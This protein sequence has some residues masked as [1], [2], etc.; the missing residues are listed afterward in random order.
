[1][2]IG[3]LLISVSEDSV[4]AAP[5]PREQVS[6]EEMAQA[7]E[8]LGQL[9]GLPEVGPEELKNKV[10]EIGG[11]R[12]LRSVPID[13]MSRDELA[14]YIRDLFEDEYPPAVAER[15]ERALR[16]LGLLESGQDLRQIRFRVL[17]ENIAGFYDERPG[18]KQLFAISSG[19]SLNLMNQ[20]ILAHELRH[21]IQDQHLQLREL[22]GKMSDY[23]DRRLAALSL[24]EGDATL[25][26][27]TYMSSGEG[28]GGAGLESLLGDLGAQAMD[29]R[30]LAEMFAGPALRDAPPV[31][32]EQL[33][34]PY[35]DGM[36]LASLIYEKGGF[37]LL[38]RKL[39]DLPRST[40]QVL[41]P[42]KYLERLDEPV[43]VHLDVGALGGVAI[44]S[45][46]RVGE[47]F[48]RTLFESVLSPGQGAEAA[49]GW[50]GDS[51]AVWVDRKGRYHLTWKTIWDTRNDAQ[52]FLNAAVQLYSAGRDSTA[53]AGGMG[54][55]SFEGSDGVRT[56]IEHN[57]REVT[58][59]REGFQ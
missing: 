18:V 2:S 1:M 45:E 4:R 6:E 25:V 50:G 8:L 59:K 33:I 41:H 5:S 43:E 3:I 42:E 11:L 24:I 23:D 30:S 35:F 34:T 39:R 31:V 37:D 12:F 28:A 16:A 49:A 38:N 32:R 51:Y 26:M 14:S 40:E 58:I 19:R 54:V 20:L 21:A 10:E 55:H 22:L 15:E 57:G 17:N 9:L 46:G 56:L 7:F 27:Q 52:E 13:F 47:L 48:I 53:T 29:A 44:E 36:R